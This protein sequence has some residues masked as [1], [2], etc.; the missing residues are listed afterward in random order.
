MKIFKQTSSTG[1]IATFTHNNI[2]ASKE[3]YLN[4]E[5]FNGFCSDYILS[6]W[7]Q[8]FAFSNDSEP[9][10]SIIDA[11][12]IDLLKLYSGQLNFSITPQDEEDFYKFVLNESDDVEFI[13]NAS[14]GL[15]NTAVLTVYDSNNNQIYQ[16]SHNGVNTSSK[17]SKTFTKNTLN[18]TAGSY[19]VA[20]TG[21]DQTGSYEFK[22]TPK[23]TLST[24]D[25]NLSN[26]VKIHPN[27]ANDKI[28]ITSE[29][30]L[31]NTKYAIYDLTGKLI[32][33]KIDLNNTKEI[34]I[35]NLESGI[36]FIQI[37]T[38]DKVVN[39]RFVKK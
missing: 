26:L 11:I 2:D 21:S 39:K 30:I 17:P 6:S 10:N 13:L 27:P 14:E 32:K 7:S 15:V 18:L 24:K 4:I 3:Y 33:S 12:D 16:L 25:N 37:K 19:F 1:P 29:E 8:G 9:N 22:I 23:I 31:N 28:F 34:N 38:I 36:Y 35:S 5:E 20:I